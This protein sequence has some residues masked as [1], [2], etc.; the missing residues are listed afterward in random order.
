VLEFG[1]IEDH[2]AAAEGVPALGDDPYDISHPHDSAVLRDEAV[3]ELMALAAR[4]EPLAGDKNAISVLWVE[5]LRKERGLLE[6]G[7]DG[8]PEQPLRRPAHEPE[9]ERIGIALPDYAIER[10]EEV[11]VVNPGGGRHRRPEVLA[12]S[13]RHAG[14][15]PSPARWNYL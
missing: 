2:A 6:P 11:L 8:K 15:V 12:V 14:A 13:L 10:L 7:S 5:P 3:F 9:S 1:D 4:V